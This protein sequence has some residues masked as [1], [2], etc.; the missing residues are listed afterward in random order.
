MK[1]YD[2]F[3]FF[4]EIEVLE[5]RLN[6]L[7]DWADQFVLVEGT[8]TF[9]NKPKDL[10]YEKNKHLF[11]KWHHKITHVIVDDAPDTEDTWAV[12]TFNFNACDRGLKE[13]K[14]DDI[15]MWSCVDEIP[16]KSSV[17][18]HIKNHTAPAMMMQYPLGSGYLNCWNRLAGEWT[19]SRLVTGAEWRASKNQ[20]NDFRKHWLGQHITNGGW[21][22]CNIGGADRYR[23]KTQSYAHKE[24]NHESFLKSLDRKI[25]YC[26]NLYDP[27]VDRHMEIM[28]WEMLPKYISENREKFKDLL[29]PNP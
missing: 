26:Y 23:L 21:H 15:V 5:I 18:E 7:D 10:V 27:E 13:L 29:I 3:T 4:N 24:L 6:E 25:E 20:Y 19:G 2:V 11:S 16:K 22:F 17:K 28:P 14:D 9:Q 12:E 1:T 8:K